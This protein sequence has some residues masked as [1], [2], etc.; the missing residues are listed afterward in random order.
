VSHCPPQIPR[1]RFGSGGQA[2]RIRSHKIGPEGLVS[3]KVSLKFCSEVQ[4]SCNV[5]KLVLRHPVL[6]KCLRKITIKYPNQT[7]FSLTRCFS[8]RAS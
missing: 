3:Y 5:S 1:H 8:D 6:L 2:S 4:V 7:Q